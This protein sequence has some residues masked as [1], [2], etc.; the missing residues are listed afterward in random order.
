MKTFL[1]EVPK[2]PKAAYADLEVSELPDF[3]EEKRQRAFQAKVGLDRSGS[4]ADILSRV[5]GWQQQQGG[6]QQQQTASLVPMFTQPGSM[7][8]FFDLLKQRQVRT[9]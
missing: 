6:Q 4:P 2:V 1:D 5:N 8:H 7:P 9:S 3:E